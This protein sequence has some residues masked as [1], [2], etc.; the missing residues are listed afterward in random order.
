[1]SRD[2]EI[3][4]KKKVVIKLTLISIFLKKKI[5]LTKISLLFLKI[6]KLKL[7]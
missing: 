6:L 5:K 4:F 1:M 3:K 7:I 2:I